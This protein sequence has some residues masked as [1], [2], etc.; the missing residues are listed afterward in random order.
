MRIQIE[1][2]KAISLM[3]KPFGW[4]RPCEYD[5]KP[6]TYEDIDDKNISQKNAVAAEWRVE[7]LCEIAIC[8]DQ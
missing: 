5:F 8:N 7:S 1:K 4:A 2:V 6:S 3:V